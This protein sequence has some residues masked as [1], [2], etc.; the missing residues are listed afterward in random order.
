MDQE[1]GLTIG[2]IR[3]NANQKARNDIFKIL[4]GKK[5]K[6]LIMSINNSKSAEH[7]SKMKM[8]QGYF[9]PNKN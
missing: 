7:P 3:N 5:R 1:I 2:S 8:K 9:Q 4:K 6:Q